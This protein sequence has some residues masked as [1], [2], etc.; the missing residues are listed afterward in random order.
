MNDNESPL[1]SGILVHWHDESRAEAAVEAWGDDPRFELLVIDN[2]SDRPFEAGSGRLIQPG[3][4]LGFAGAVNLGLQQ[5]KASLVLILNTDCRAEP[6]ALDQILEGFEIHPEAAGLVPRLVGTDRESQHGWQLRSLPS[7]L[8]LALQACMIP[9]GSGP[10]NSPPPGSLI[11]QPAAAALAMRRQD[12][13]TIGGMDVRFHPAW[14]ED[15]DLAARLRSDKRPLVYWPLA[16]FT[17]DLGSSVATLG[18]GLFLWAHYRNMYR[19]LGKHHGSI[20]AEISRLLMVPA[21]LLRMALVPLRKPSR[22]TN[23][24]EAIFGLRDHVLGAISRWRF[25]RRYVERFQSP[26]APAEI[27]G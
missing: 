23:R 12:L 25:P 26:P 5:S 13:E 27:K 14:F 20:W 17:H 2:G 8:Q 10:R 4:N 21:A 16:T 6:G 18:Y 9:V 3:R 24:I 7:T 1:L 19:Y 11:E 15:V 22:A